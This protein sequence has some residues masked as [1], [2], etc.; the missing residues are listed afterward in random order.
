MQLGRVVDADGHVLE[1][2][3]LWKNNLETKFRN[4]APFLVRDEEGYESLVVDGKPSPISRGLG[5]ASAYGC[6]RNH[7]NLSLSGRVDRHLR[8]GGE[9][10]VVST[11]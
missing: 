5:V 2:P 7:P 9:D 8:R 11:L 10:D 4:R 3:D 6:V 1:P